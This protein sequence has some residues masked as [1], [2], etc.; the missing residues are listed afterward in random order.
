MVLRCLHAGVST[1]CTP[2][3]VALLGK[4]AIIKTGLSSANNIL[5]QGT[6][7]FRRCTESSDTTCRRQCHT[8]FT[9]VDQIDNVYHLYSATG[10]ESGEILSYDSC[11][12]SD[13]DE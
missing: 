13:P 3:K 2:V 1:E 9:L 12:E 8:E 5:L 10:L 4:V 11:S 7:V 6:P